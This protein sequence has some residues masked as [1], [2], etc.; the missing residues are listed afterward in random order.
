MPFKWFKETTGHFY[1][2]IDTVKMCRSVVCVEKCV[3]LWMKK[4]VQE[5][6]VGICCM[7]KE[8]WTTERKQFRGVAATLYETTNSQEFCIIVEPGQR[9]W[10][11]YTYR[12]WQKSCDIESF[13]SSKY[14]QADSNDVYEKIGGLIRQKKRVLFIGTPCQC[15]AA[16][17]LYNSKEY[18]ITVDLICH[19]VP[20]QSTFKII[21]NGYRRGEKIK[22]I[23]EASFR[24]P[25]GEEMTLKSQ[26]VIVI[27]KRKMREDYYLDAFNSGMLNNEACYECRYAWR[28]V[29]QRSNNWRF[30]GNRKERAICTP[31]RK[32]SVTD[33]YAKGNGIIR[34]VISWF[35]NDGRAFLWGEAAGETH[36]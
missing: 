4:K 19:S 2:V 15:A 31:G 18:L 34:V 7:E 13:K 17:K 16:R 23:T 33:K 6:K 32:V 3:R 11:C 5:Y 22:R 21:W 25:Y 10:L 24:T 27:W 36:S 30:L 26:G 1:P 29:R 28:N 35:L 12:K 9:G 14:V 8:C 20:L